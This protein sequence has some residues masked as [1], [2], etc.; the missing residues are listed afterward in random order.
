MPQSLV[1]EHTHEE[2]LEEGE[3]I[4]FGVLDG[5][6]LEGEGKHG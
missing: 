3:L 6:G 5:R 4:G 1:L 2:G